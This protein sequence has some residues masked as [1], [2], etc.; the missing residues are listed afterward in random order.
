[1][2]RPKHHPSW[3]YIHHAVLAVL[4]SMFALGIAASPAQAQTFTVLHT[5]SGPDGANP[6]AAPVLDAAGNLYGPTISG[7]GAAYNGTIFKLAYRGSGWVLSSLYDFQGGNDGGSPKAGLTL[8]RSGV[9]YGSTSLGGGGD[10]TPGGCGTVFKLRPPA[11]FCR[12]VICPWG[13]TQLYAIENRPDGAYPNSPVIFDQAGNVYGTTEEGGTGFGV[14]Y[15]LT[16]SGEGWAENVVHVFTG[17]SDGAYPTGVISDAAGNLYGTT[18]VHGP[19]GYGTVFRLTNS[20]SGWTL[21]NLYGFHATGDGKVPY[22]R[23]VSDQFGNLYGTTSMGGGGDDG[24]TIYELSPQNGSWTYT[25]L[26]SFPSADSYPSSL[27]LDATGNLYGEQEA[28]GYG[29]GS[30]FKLTH[31]GNGWTYSELYTFTGG[32]DGSLPIDTVVIDRNGN[33]YGVAYYGGNGYCERGC[34]TVWEITQ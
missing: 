10:C 20:G 13:K 11:T 17:M 34:G 30:V 23:L 33:L 29:A 19:Y 3:K 22:G 6:S 4:T 21:T 8:D 7:T 24:G 15:Q 28:G 18:T 1:M 27:V 26:Y 31:F 2:A 12:S 14:V 9:V 5:F 25:V 32:S 16:P